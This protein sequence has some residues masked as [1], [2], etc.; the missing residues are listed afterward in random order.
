MS[1]LVWGL[2]KRG[3]LTHGETVPVGRVSE[4]V[5]VLADAVEVGAGQRGG[6]LYELVG[7]DERAQARVEAATGNRSG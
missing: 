4:V 3:R 5:A 7:E 6:E 1:G 2:G